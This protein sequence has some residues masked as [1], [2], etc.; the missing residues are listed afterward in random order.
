MNIYL[1]HTS[2]WSNDVNIQQEYKHCMCTFLSWS[3]VENETLLDFT[4]LKPS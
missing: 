4:T 2:V 3:T 1:L